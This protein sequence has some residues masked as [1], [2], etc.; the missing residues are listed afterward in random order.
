MNSQLQ[1]IYFSKKCPYFYYTLLGLTVLVVLVTIVDGF[2]IAES[3]MF[4]AL[5]FLLNLLI[6]LDFCFKV[7]MQG[8]SKFFKLDM[9]HKSS[10]WWNYFDAFV[11]LS[12]GMLFV[13][14]VFAK[15]GLQ[16]DIDESL[17]QLVMIIWAAWQILRVFLI[18]KK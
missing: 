10:W 8:L 1:R 12:C 13:G 6:T 15:H 7:K 17:E 9:Q 18:T 16:K 14:T 5:E 11:V 2:K 3:P 4:I